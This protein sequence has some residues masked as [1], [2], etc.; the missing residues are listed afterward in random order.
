LPRRPLLVSVEGID[1][2][3]KTHV[4]RLLAE[5]LRARGLHVDVL[6]KHEARFG[7]TFADS[8]L[9]L[10]RAAIW[11]REPEPDED[12]LGTHFSLFLLAAWLAALKRLVAAAAPCD[13]RITDGT[14]FRVVAKAH[15]RSSLAIDWLLSLFEDALEPDCIAL[16]DIDPAQAWLRR[17]SFKATEVGRWDGFA[18]E[19]RQAFVSYQGKVRAVLLSFAEERGWAVVRQTASSDPD[20]VCSA[21]EEAL[22][23]RLLDG[24]LA[25]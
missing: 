8:R 9:D 6:D 16:L 10:L 21:V 17:P 5:R 15:V 11:P 13:V 18:G 24:R 19:P 7:D 4:S 14:Y 12:V 1:G 20:H 25:P 23:A 22:G 3:G 2:A